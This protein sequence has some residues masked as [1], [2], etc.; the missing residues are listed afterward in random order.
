LDD[1][2]TWEVSTYDWPSIW[3][4]QRSAA[5]VPVPSAP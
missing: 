1:E 3:G 4:H 5:R 2:E